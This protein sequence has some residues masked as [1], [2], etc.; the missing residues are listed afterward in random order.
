[1]LRQYIR[2]DSHLGEISLA[3]FYLK[4]YSNVTAYTI[5]HLLCKVKFNWLQ[6][7]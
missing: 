3:K 2:L 5:G 4:L 1:M 7:T 6:F